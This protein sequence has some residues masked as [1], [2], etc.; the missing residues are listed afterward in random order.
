MRAL[1]MGVMGLL[2]CVI[3]AA[4]T[5]AHSA[6]ANGPYYATPSWDQKLDPA[7]RFIVL[8][9]WGSQAVLDRETGLVWEQSPGSGTHNW[10]FAHAHC[11]QKSVGNRRGWRM[12]TIQELTSLTDPAVASGTPSLPP[13]HPFGNVQLTRYWSATTGTQFANAAWGVDFGTNQILSGLTKEI[14]NLHPVW[15]V[16]GGHGNE[17]Q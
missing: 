3:G 5:V 4:G 17:V 12:P 2:A 13:G 10:F 1:R 7:A 6:T 11:V 9:N 8:A 16:R 14:T 15:C